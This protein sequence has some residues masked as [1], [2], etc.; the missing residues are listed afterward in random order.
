MNSVEV[1]FTEQDLIFIRDQA[2][3]YWSEMNANQRLPGSIRTLTEEEVRALA[4]LRA[5]A[6]LLSRKGCGTDII[7]ELH[8][9][10][11]EPDTE[12]L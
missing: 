10:S 6:D 3:R 7:P 12:D 2:R 5:S 9:P 4:W 11:S 8:T 1:A